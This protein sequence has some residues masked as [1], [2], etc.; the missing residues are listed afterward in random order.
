MPQTILSDLAK[1]KTGDLI[2][3]IHDVVCGMSNEETEFISPDEVKQ[4]VE[5]VDELRSRSVQAEIKDKDLQ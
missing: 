1:M 2:D 3:A 4:L 5:L